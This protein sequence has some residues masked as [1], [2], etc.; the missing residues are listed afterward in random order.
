MSKMFKSVTETWNPYH[1]CEHDCTYCWARKA[2][3]GRLKKLNDRY[4]D[5]FTPAFFPDMLARRFK[6]GSLVFVS[7]MGDLFGRWVK[8]EWIAAIL[9]VVAQH[10]D[11]DFL[12]CTKNPDRYLQFDFSPNVILGVTIETT[13]DHGVYDVSKAPIPVLRYGAMYLK[14]HP[15]KFISIEPVMDFDLGEL[16]LW[17]R[18]I[19]PEIVE[20]GADTLNNNLPEPDTEKLAALVIGCES[21]VAT[22]HLKDSLERLL[23][24]HWKDLAKPLPPLVKGKLG[25]DPGIIGNKTG[26]EK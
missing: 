20:I 26:G 1:G 7:D 14:E 22:V 5:G 4:K 6:A 8:R 23:P 25:G 12:F 18:Q 9:E 13:R 3:E 17:V 15:R 2:A 19:K 11:V 10:P 16:L 24:E 21:E